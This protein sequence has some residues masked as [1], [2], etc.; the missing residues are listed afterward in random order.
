MSITALL[1]LK[2]PAPRVFDFYIIPLIVNR[3]PRYIR[4]RNP[5][6]VTSRFHCP[7]AE[8]SNL[9]ARRSG[10]CKNQLKANRNFARGQFILSTVNHGRPVRAPT[11]TDVRRT[12]T[13]FVGHV[14][15]QWK[16]RFDSRIISLGPFVEGWS[17]FI[18]FYRIP[19]NQKYPPWHGTWTKRNWN[20]KPA[21]CA[22]TQPGETKHS[23]ITED[24]QKF[25]KFNL[26][27]WLQFPW[28]SNKWLMKRKVL[29]G[30]IEKNL[31]NNCVRVLSPKML[32]NKLSYH[33]ETVPY[34][35]PSLTLRGYI[36]L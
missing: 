35:I 7:I 21:D 16:R 11:H 36:F 31:W 4:L 22:R 27:N 23:D 30:F 6:V 15:M 19:Q 10:R 8:L 1:H 28:I 34:Y 18:S 32:I 29:L 12:R 17:W 9:C 26:G 3:P 24:P 5:S 13:E 33:L 2:Y 25:T 14:Q 20:E